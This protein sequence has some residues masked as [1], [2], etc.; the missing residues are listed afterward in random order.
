VGTATKIDS[1][2]IRWPSGAIDKLTNISLNK[3]IK[4]VEGVGQSK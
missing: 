3:Y 4:V 2:E 1:I